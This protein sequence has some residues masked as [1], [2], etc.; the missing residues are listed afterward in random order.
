M[1]FQA[2]HKAKH[3]LQPMISRDH[4]KQ[5]L[6]PGPCR[7]L[8]G[9]AF[10]AVGDQSAPIGRCSMPDCRRTGSCRGRQATISHV[11]VDCFV[12]QA[13]GQHLCKLLVFSRPRLNKHAH[14]RWGHMLHIPRTR[15]QV[16]C[17][18]PSG[19]VVDCC[20]AEQNAAPGRQQEHCNWCTS[21]W[22]TQPTCGRPCARECG[23]APSGRLMSWS[24]RSAWRLL[25][26]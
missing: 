13:H 12:R 25:A 8:P 9:S 2:K 17:T 11:V 14:G 20:D 24:P 21:A 5:R 26:P 6:Y 18:D 7:G 23:C 4:R 3:C 19:R 22:P 16:G 1:S 15:C 10:T